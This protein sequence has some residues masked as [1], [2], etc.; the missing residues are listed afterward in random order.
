MKS[1]Y[2]IAVAQAMDAQHAALVQLRVNPNTYQPK[3]LST[4]A[5]AH[6]GNRPSAT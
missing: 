2:Q 3:H 5:S 1:L 6:R 4:Q